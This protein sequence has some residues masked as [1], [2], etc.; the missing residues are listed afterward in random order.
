MHFLRV[1]TTQREL[2][3]DITDSVQRLVTENGWTTG[4]LCLFCMHTT[5]ALTVNENADRSVPRD[6]LSTLQRLVPH[7][8]EYHHVEGN[9]DAHIKASL[10][11]PEQLLLVENG[12]LVLGTWQGVFFTEF[13]GPR[14]RR[15]AAR[16]MP[17]S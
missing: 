9:S 11:G 3:V 15:V 10:M 1:E 4:I 6:I 17:A 5:A 13:D 14:S 2:F 8:G 12:R 16:W 7:A